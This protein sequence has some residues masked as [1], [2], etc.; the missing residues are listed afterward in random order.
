V[1]VYKLK[2]PDISWESDKIRSSLL[3]REVDYKYIENVHKPEYLYWDKVR[4]KSRPEGFS[5]DE[6]WAHIKFYRRLFSG[7][8]KTPV[9]DING[10]YF[11]WQPLPDQDYFLHQVD[12]QLGG[13]LKSRFVDNPSVR[14]R[15]IGRG[16][17][18]EAIASSQLEG[19]VTTRRVA[20]K[21]ILEKRKP[22]NR[23]DQ[24]ILN[25]YYAMLE[26]EEN[27]KKQPMSKKMLLDLHITIT[28]DTI[29]DNEIG[30]FRRDKDN[31]VVCDVAKNIAYHIPPPVD[32]LEREIKRFIQYANDNLD[33]KRFVHPLIKAIILHFW[34]GYLHPFTDGNGR[35]A[36]IVFY[37]YLLRNDYWAFSY[38]PVSRIIRDSPKQYRMAYVYSEQDDNDLTYFLDYNIR[39]IMQAKREFE[40]YIEGKEAE[41]RYMTQIAQGKYK[42]NYRQIQL[43]KLLHKNSNDSRT[44]KTHSVVNNIS[45]V[46]ARKEL[47]KLERLGFLS[48]EKVGKERP[49]RGTDKI[50]EL[51]S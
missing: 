9:K 3:D 46:T 22:A 5:A 13:L 45:R 27:L 15:F 20:K 18:E 17:M 26:A 34:I 12:M 19:A 36:R 10:K 24:M 25:N 21:L 29:K 33:E 2:K 43:L 39:K 42:L 35:M 4:Y 8:T 38:L 32:F 14:Q 51:F 44:I 48:S 49:F 40:T 30:R 16:I 7:R 37:W 23:S 31:I 11:T 47:E 50:S 1:E 6:F 41:N 28:K